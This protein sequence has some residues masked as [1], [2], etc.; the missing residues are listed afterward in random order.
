[1]SDSLLIFDKAHLMPMKYMQP[2][3]QVVAYMTGKKKI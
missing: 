2:C 1:M 3:L